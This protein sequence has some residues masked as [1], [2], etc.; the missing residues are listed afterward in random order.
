MK[1]SQMEF[2]VCV[3]EI[4]IYTCPQKKVTGMHIISEKITSQWLREVVAPQ[5]AYLSLL[6]QILI[7][8]VVGPKN[9]DC[10]P[11]DH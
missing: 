1:I 9:I 5:F 11:L 10:T 3:C 7:S 6:D 8:T 4:G 2:G